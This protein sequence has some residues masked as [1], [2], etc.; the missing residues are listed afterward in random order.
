MLAVGQIVNESLDMD[1]ADEA[2]VLIPHALQPTLRVN[3]KLEVQFLGEE[4]GVYLS[5]KASRVREATGSQMS[6]APFRGLWTLEKTTCKG[7][8]S[9]QSASSRCP[10]TQLVASEK[11]APV[12]VG[13]ASSSWSVMGIYLGVVYTI[14]RLLRGVFQDSS[15]RVIYEEIPDTSLLEDLCNGI[16]IARIQRFLRTE[17]K[18]FYQLMNILRS[19]ELL[20]NVTGNFCDKNFD[21]E[22]DLSAEA[23]EEVE[24]PEGGAKE[25]WRTIVEEG[26]H[27]SEETYVVPETFELLEDDLRQME[28]L[29]VLEE[30]HVHHVQSSE[31]SSRG[32]FVGV[33]DSRA[34]EIGG[35]QM[36]P[37]SELRRRQG[38]RP[39]SRD[40]DRVGL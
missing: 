7:A 5:F 26:E 22:M 36:S 25:Q 24:R 32:R 3:A 4:S 14:G 18:L 21:N 20:L 6:P 33:T 11:S 19:P 17:Y 23:E 13:G 28:D 8:D 2:G 1:S 16:Y 9:S 37:L 27:E 34:C 35:A 30:H 10:I 38:R 31:M 12:P 15:K 40:G 39:M 29:E